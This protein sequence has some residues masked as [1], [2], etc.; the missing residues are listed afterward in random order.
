[1]LVIGVYNTAGEK[2]STIGNSPVSN[3]LGA[4]NITVNG[5]AS[6]VF[7]PDDGSGSLMITLPG[8]DSELQPANPQGAVFLWNGTTS[9]GQQVS[10][11]IYYIKFTMQDEYG[12]VVTVVKE[13]QVISS[14][15]YTRISIYNSA[16]ELVQRINL[17]A[18]VSSAI[19]LAVDDVVTVG[20]GAP[21]VQIGYA[22][23]DTASWDGTNAE[24]A[25]VGSGIYEIKVETVNV[26]GVNVVVSKSITVLNGG[27][28][29]VISNVE[30]IPNPDIITDPSTAGMQIK[31]LAS[32]TGK[33]DIQVNNLSGELVAHINSTL[34]SGSASWDLHT[35]SGQNAAGGL[36]I[37]II[38]ADSDTGE[39]GIKIMKAVVVRK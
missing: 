2:V 25:L 35:Q 26:D 17:P 23:G 3:N 5:A 28:A 6:A 34:Q 24:G 16:G 1:V 31:W 11:G 33:V 9:A 30:I 37:M 14:A 22:A 7:D 38:K 15:S 19:S 4:I 27:N 20:K 39:T 36:Y 13:I 12:A 32:G 29:G 21:A 10:P 18:V 8:V